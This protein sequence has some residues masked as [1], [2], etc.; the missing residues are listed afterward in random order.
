V[1]RSL[2]QRLTTVGVPVISGMAAGID[3]AAHQGS[4]AARVQA[5]GPAPTVAVLP[6]P[7]HQAYPRSASALHRRLL[8]AA[9]APSRRCR[10]APASVAGC[11]WPET[12]SSP[13]WPR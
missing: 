7:A 6:G 12:G 11:S 4:L 9:A 13:G 10:P 2:A 1:A 5:H 3:S 8:D